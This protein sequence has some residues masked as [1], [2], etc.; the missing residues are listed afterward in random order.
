[1]GRLKTLPSRLGK[2]APAL[3]YVDAPTRTPD[4]ARSFFAPWRKLYGTARWRE[5][6]LRIFARDGFTCQHPGCGFMTANTSKLIC[7]HRKPHRG[8][9]ALF[10]DD[11]NLVTLCKPHHDRDK[12]RAERAG[13][14]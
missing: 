9:E 1:M 11:D 7:D 13:H 12:Q 6:R 3:G 14:S 8:D 5:T 2:L 10:W 4:A